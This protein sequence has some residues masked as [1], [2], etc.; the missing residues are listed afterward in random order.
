M[1][2]LYSTHQILRTMPRVSL[3]VSPY[4]FAWLAANLHQRWL[5]TSPR[6]L[7]AQ[8]RW[9]LNCMNWL[10]SSRVWPKKKPVLV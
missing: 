5:H 3:K 2:S 10:N 1:Q 6:I 8:H 9:P 4:L 7:R